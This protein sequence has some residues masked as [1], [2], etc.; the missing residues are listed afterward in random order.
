MTPARMA[1]QRYLLGSVALIVASSLSCATLGGATI[2]P[3]LQKSSNAIAKQ[4]EESGAL[5]DAP[6]LTAYI[7]A[8]GNRLVAQAKAKPIEKFSFAVLD[9]SEPNAFSI[10]SGHIYISRGLL[11]LMGTE[12]ELAG[13]IG[14]EIGHV[15]EQHSLKQ[16][17]GSLAIAPIRLVTRL[18]GAL[19]GLIFPR[20]GKLVTSTVEVPAALTGASYGRSQENEA[21]DV[22]QRLAAAGGWDPMALSRVMDIFA[23]ETEMQ[24]EDP[25]NISWFSTHPASPD[26]AARIRAQANELTVGTLPPIAESRGVFL[27]K[28]EGLVVGPSARNGVFVGSDFYHPGLGFALRFPSGEEWKQI[29]TDRA[30]AVLRELPPAVVILAVVAEGDNALA[31]AEAFKPKSGEFDAPPTGETVNGLATARATGHDKGGWRGA[32]QPMRASARWIAHQGLIYRIVSESTEHGYSISAKDFD[33]TERSF[34][35]LTPADRQK[36]LEDRLQIEI[37][38]ANETL[39][40]LLARTGSEWDLEEAAAANDIAADSRLSQGDPVKITH[41]TLYQVER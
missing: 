36:I 35:I 25:A 10:P 24:G 38:R 30:V 37:A 22:G 18:G 27:S 41:R 31:V 13:V 23:R 1:R 28:L 11:T 39:S 29:N 8:I 15:L 19:V 40:E 33:S 5:V 32:T 9:Q 21:D 7:T 16:I 26:R 4:L 20:V 34:R 2:G 6:A 12:D 14:H 17:T 3:T